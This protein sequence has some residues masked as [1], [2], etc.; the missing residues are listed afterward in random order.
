MP[1]AQVATGLVDDPLTQLTDQAKALGHR[2]ELGGADHASGRVVPAQQR[3]DASQLA[4]GG[5]QLGLEVQR[6]LVAGHGVAQVAL[7]LDLGCAHA[8]HAT[9]E[10]AVH[11]TT[12][13]AG[14]EHGVIGVRHQLLGRGAVGVTGHA[15]GAADRDLLVLHQA[16][17]VHGV[18]QALGQHGG[19]VFVVE[20]TASD[21]E[22]IGVGA[23]QHVAFTDE[24]LQPERQRLD[25][26]IAHAVPI[27]AREGVKAVDVQPHHAQVEHLVGGFVDEVTHLLLEARS[28]G[29]PGGRVTQGGLFQRGLRGLEGVGQGLVSSQ[30]AR[31]LQG[32]D[33][34]H[35]EQ[36]EHGGGE[37][38]LQRVTGELPLAQ[39]VGRQGDADR[40]DLQDQA[41]P[42]DRAHHHGDGQVAGLVVIS[43]ELGLHQQGTQRAPEQDQQEGGAR[44]LGVPDHGRLQH[45]GRGV[46]EH[47]HL[48]A[49]GDQHGTQQAR[50]PA[51]VAVGLHPDGS[52]GD[53]DGRQPG[54]QH[55][56]AHIAHLDGQLHRHQAQKAR[57]PDARAHDERAAQDPGQAGFSV[58]GPHSADHHALQ[59]D[60]VHGKQPGRR[61]G[62][63]APACCHEG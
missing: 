52:C 24:A 6:Q 16:R 21:Q 38:E 25:Q 40:A 42:D 39:A 19:D 48:H 18:L 58:I 12:C 32:A 7:H 54:R 35:H 22:L 63:A 43:V 44:R 50:S 30:V 20:P 10:E 2:D 5:A 55:D 45:D 23:R 1:H 61:E 49:H 27:G 4:R 8:V 13:A 11:A 31:V 47:Q 36:D 56:V 41:R 59:R 57:R 29:Q 53:D 34:R 46:D 62:R 3:F 37:H 15:D 9:L 14:G 17:L 60:G 26:A 51:Q 28:V 33:V